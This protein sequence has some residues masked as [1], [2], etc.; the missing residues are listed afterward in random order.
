MLDGLVLWGESVRVAALTLTGRISEEEAM[1]LPLPL[2]RVTL[3][4]GRWWYACSG[5]WPA[6]DERQQAVTYVNRRPDMEGFRRMT[7]CKSVDIKA[8]P[9]KLIHRPRYV[10]S[11]WKRM[12]WTCIGDPDL[13]RRA[14][15]FVHGIGQGV[16]EGIG[17][18]HPVTGWEVEADPDGP[19]LDAYR[20]DARIRPLP[21]D[22]AEPPAV[23]NYARCPVPLRAPYW[24]RGNTELCWKVT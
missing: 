17:T 1:R 14:L 8:G 3:P 21:I 19:K 7:T 15:R 20:T 6:P 18:V 9:D 5:A 12:E 10:W 11:F 2:E 23:P 13:L 16:P 22:V 24:M 4:D